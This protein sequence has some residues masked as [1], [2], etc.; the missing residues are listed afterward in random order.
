[1]A[2][3][4]SITLAILAGGEGSRMGRPKGEI[5]VG[6]IPILAYLL[7]RTAWPGPTL[8]VTAPGREHPPAWERFDREVSDPVAGEGPLRGVL[9]AIEN[10][11]T[12]AIVVG[13]VDMPGVD[14]G[15]LDWL[16]HEFGARPESLGVMCV[17]V[18]GQIEPFP[19]GLRKTAAPLIRAAIADGRR[20]VHGLA[21]STEVVALPVPPDWP[22]TIWTNLNRPEDLAAWRDSVR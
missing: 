21:E 5:I 2:L 11:Q 14:R 19:C 4:E 18:D 15:A 10:C 6:C 20:S 13:T 8:L 9:T 16:V 1:M 3:E 7:D 17:R 12:E 22:P